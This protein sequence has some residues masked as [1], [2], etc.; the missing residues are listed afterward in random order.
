MSAVSPGAFVPE[1]EE[2]MN[3]AMREEIVR[4]FDELAGAFDTAGRPL[5][6]TRPCLADELAAAAD[7]VKG[8]LSGI[9]VAIVRG[10]ADLVTDADGRF[11]IV[12]QAPGAYQLTARHSLFS[13]GTARV[14][15]EDKD[16]L[17]DIPVVAG[18]VIADRYGRAR[19]IQ[20]GNLLSGAVQGVIAALVALVLTPL[21]WKPDEHEDPGPSSAEPPRYV[22]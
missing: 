18:G 20:A 5:V 17:V 10:R 9:P 22:E 6:V 11:E 15:L 8:K 1:F 16:G 13:E 14:T 7:L 19:V 12:D 2:A 21:R 4:V 3:R